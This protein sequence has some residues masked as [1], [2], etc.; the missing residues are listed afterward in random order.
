MT[1]PQPGRTTDIVPARSLDQLAVT[2]RH[3]IEAADQHW[4]SAVRHAIRAGDGLIEAKRLLRH[5]EWLAWLAVSFPGFSERSARNY[6]RLARNGNAVADMPSIRQAIALLAA[7]K[8]P[9]PQAPEPEFKPE[10]FEQEVEARIEAELGPAPRREDYTADNIGE[11]FRELRYLSD[12]LEWNRDRSI[13]LYRMALAEC[14]KALAD[15]G[16]AD[17]PVEQ[18]AT[19][20]SWASTGIT[21]ELAWRAMEHADEDSYEEKS[22]AAFEALHTYEAARDAHDAL[23]EEVDA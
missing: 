12:W 5:G 6:M 1:D 17:P 23:R 8:E 14:A 11:E 9:E 19:C 21:Y 2:I 13:A 4:Q 22:R 18:V 15:P 3:D 10:V 7:P 16:P 20:A